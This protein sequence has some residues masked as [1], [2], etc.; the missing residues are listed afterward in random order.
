[1]SLRQWACLAGGRKTAS[2]IETGDSEHIRRSD[3]TGEK[4]GYGLT[5]GGAGPRRIGGGGRRDTRRGRAHRLLDGLRRIIRRAGRAL[6]LTEI[7]GDAEALVA[8]VLDRLDLAAAHGHRKAALRAHARLGGA[9]A[10]A[11]GRVEYRGDHRLQFAAALHR[12][13]FIRSHSSLPF[14]RA[15]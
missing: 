5:G 1:M 3:G 11:R 10:L 14:R 9:R 13:L 12:R 15:V 7:H 2:L 8:V 4:N 6:S